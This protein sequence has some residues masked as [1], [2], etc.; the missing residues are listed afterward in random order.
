MKK[1]GLI[2]IVIVG[3]CIIFGIMQKDTQIG[4]NKKQEEQYVVEKRKDLILTGVVKTDE[5]R[6]LTK[7][8]VENILIKNGD[9]VESG[10]KIYLNGYQAPISGTFTMT[11]DGSLK[12]L[13][14]KQHIESTFKETDIDL[15][16][17]GDEVKISDI[18]GSNNGKSKI[19]TV[20]IIPTDEENNDMSSYS[21]VLKSDKRMVGQHVLVYIPQVTVIIPK[22]YVDSKK[23]WIKKYGK[24]DW[25]KISIKVVNKGGVYF[26][27][28]SEIPVG[29]RLKEE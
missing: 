24:H 20:G 22:K 26:A 7:T 23:V 29:S 27:P 8:N 9:H 13:S 21:L 18:E 25:G 5:I 11:G 19:E 14:D 2:A 6:V 17:Q 15:L 10:Q 12:I 16:R 3:F 28:I 4:K 1:I